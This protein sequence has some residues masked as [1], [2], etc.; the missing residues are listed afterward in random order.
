M[1]KL[2]RDRKMLC[3]KRRDSEFQF[4]LKVY[5]FKSISKLKP[6]TS[7]LFELLSIISPYI[8][9]KDSKNNN[10]TTIVLNYKT[11]LKHN[12]VLSKPCK[13]SKRIDAQNSLFMLLTYY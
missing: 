2:E 6:Y 3:N 5:Y 8:N 10:K 11:A 4:L 9:T 12:I 7:E 1:Y 13:P